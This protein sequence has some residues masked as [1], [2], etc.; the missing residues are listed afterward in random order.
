ME[1]TSS[2]RCWR[3]RT[4]SRRRTDPFASYKHAK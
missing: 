4:R 1:R 2:A 3:K